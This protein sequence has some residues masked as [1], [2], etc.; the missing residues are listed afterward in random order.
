MRLPEPARMER[1]AIVAPVSRMTAVLGAVAAAGVVE[2]DILLSASGGTIAGASLESVSASAVTHGSVAAVAGWSPAAA[3]D[4]LAAQLAPL[5]GGVVT[6]PVP[7]GAEPPT[8]VR[9]GSAFQPLVDVYATIPYADVNPSLFAGL[10]Y[11]LMFGMMFGDVGHGALLLAGGIWMWRAPSG[12]LARY[13]KAAPFVA[14]A[15]LTS[16]AFGVAYGEAFGPTGLVRALWLEPL[17]QP[18][19]LIVAAI[20]V[21]AVLLAI[22][23]GLGSANRW[24]EG[25][26]AFALLALSGFAGSALYLG[27]ALIAAGWFARSGALTTAGIVASI[28]GAVLGY[29]G[30]YAQSGGH[31]AGALEAGVEVFDAVI[32]LGANTVSFAR[33]AAFGLTHAAIGGI[34]W[35][36]TTA[37][38]GRGGGWFALAALVFVLGNALAFTLEALVAGIQALRLDYY[39]LFSRIFISTGRAFAP[40]HLS[41]SE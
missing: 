10:A 33:L 20:G 8:L 14:G 23:Y 26:P 7:P 11:I 9:G 19:T 34:V 6:L 25:G 3:I 18:V 13:R 35:S 28:G 2:P 4:P 17:S 21:G 38:A 41:A 37:L 36:G 5:G 1:V 15:G 40:W 39:E 31:A 32:R 16:M 12:P 27:F 30:L 22:S 29:A 24:R